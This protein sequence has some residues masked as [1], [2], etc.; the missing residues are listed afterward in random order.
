MG[1]RLGETR[2]QWSVSAAHITF[3]P[4]FLRNTR[5]SAP[6]KEISAEI[7]PFSITT[8]DSFISQRYNPSLLAKE[9]NRSLNTQNIYLPNLPLMS[10]RQ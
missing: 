8:I 1:N 5:S 3:S 9:I 10:F 2:F 6:N 7:E 4:S